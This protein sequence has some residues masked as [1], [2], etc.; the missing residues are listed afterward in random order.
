MYVGATH[1]G[2]I[3][4]DVTGNV[5]GTVNIDSNGYGTFSVLGGSHSVWVNKN[6]DI[7]TP[8]NTVTIYYK[9]KWANTYIHYQVGSGE[10]T[11]VPGVCMEDNGDGYAKITLNIGKASSIKACFNDGGSNWDNNGEK[12]Y[13][14]GAGTYRINNGKLVAEFELEE[15]P[16]SKKEETTTSKKEEETTTSKKEEETTT[17]K[18]EE[19]TTTSSVKVDR[20]KN[21]KMSK[22][23][24]SSITL[25]WDKVSNASG[26]KIYRYNKSTKKYA[27][28]KNVKGKTS[29]T[30]SKLNAG[31]TYRYY[32]VAYKI[33]DG[34]TYEGA[35]SS[36][37]SACTTPKRV[38][39]TL[40]A[41]GNKI[42]KIYW[43][44]VSGATGYYVYYKQKG[45]SKWIK[46]ANLSKKKISFT[47]KN[48]KKNKK[49]SIKVVAYRRAGS[50]VAKST[51]Y[52][53]TIKVK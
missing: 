21:L 48:L 23:T 24:T 26:Y 18:K 4:H 35:K 29:Y 15:E 19:E 7:E 8:E 25:K 10:W 45:T 31:N 43:N 51:S 1:A 42:V 22:S 2:E 28:L 37:V 20:V 46:A 6:S 5:S 44:K 49:Y 53:K 34:T 17:S 50:T 52:I 27:L 14:I 36:V 41:K 40:K 11:T 32:V 16:D 3:W 39:F 38:K 9:K 12:N 30:N 47:K 33:V 13:Y